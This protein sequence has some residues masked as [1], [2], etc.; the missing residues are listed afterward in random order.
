MQ[1]NSLTEALQLA[2]KAKKEG[3]ALSIGL[4]GNAAEIL[5]KMNDIGFT[6][7][8]LTDQTSAHDPLYGYIPIYYSR[9]AAKH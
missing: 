4:L 3:R 5:P 8:I 7:Q 9:K 2:E 1:T 6:P